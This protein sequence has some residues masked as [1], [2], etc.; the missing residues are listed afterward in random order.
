MQQPCACLMYNDQ[1]GAF[2][3]NR[4]KRKG[5]GTVGGTYQRAALST[6][7]L[8]TFSPVSYARNVGDLHW[9]QT[10]Y[11]NR[12]FHLFRWPFPLSLALSS[13][14]TRM[15]FLTAPACN[16]LM[17]HATRGTRFI[18][19]ILI[20]SRL[21]H[22]GAKWKQR[23]PA[24]KWPLT[25]LQGRDAFHFHSLDCYKPSDLPLQSGPF[26]KQKSSGCRLR[27]MTVAILQLQ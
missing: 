6:R 26:F 20:R 3:S 25:G 2:P 22:M 18:P 19:S 21:W 27:I 12:V 15:H 8:S 23:A 5:A 11:P 14:P 16:M 7:G 9:L 17:A 10:H 1:V 4:R 13:R 24:K